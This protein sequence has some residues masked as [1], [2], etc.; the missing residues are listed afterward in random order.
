MC[1]KRNS[2][3]ILVSY[4]KEKIVRIDD[5]MFNLIYFINTSMAIKTLGCCCG[6]N[7]Y[8]MSVIVQNQFTGE[9]Y[10]FM[11]GIEINRKK[12]FYKKNKKTG[13]YYIPE[14]VSTTNQTKRSG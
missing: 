12:K 3:G 7:K 6:H 13:Y 2:K 10:E 4:P 5:C 1:N 8:P 11:T 9:I 14:V